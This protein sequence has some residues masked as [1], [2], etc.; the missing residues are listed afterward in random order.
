MGEISE[1]LRRARDEREAA[2]DAPGR[3]RVHPL[4]AEPGSDAPATPLHI[5]REQRDHW[6]PRAVLVEAQ[7]PVAERFRHLAIRIRADLERREPPVLVVTSATPGEGKTTTACNLALALA[8]IASGRRIALVEL[9]LRRPVL[10]RVLDLPPRDGIES[11]LAGQTS[12]SAA[13]VPTDLS[14]LDVYPAGRPVL[15][16]HELLSGPGL[17]TVLRDLTRRY[18]MVVCDSPPVVPVPDV[19]LLS[20]HAGACLAV[21]RAGVT[22]RAA[23]R[24]MLELVPRSKFLG[25]F[26]N[27]AQARSGGY[28]YAYYYTDIEPE[29]AER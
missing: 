24:H 19:P 9:D 21:A 8:S 17:V 16:A 28:D 22:R 26:L 15:R 23:F 5:S 12:L 7:Q 20:E 13:C 6:V 10:G 29:R 1:A 25:V 27:D 14:G 18:A 4:P 3:M 11:V 2:E